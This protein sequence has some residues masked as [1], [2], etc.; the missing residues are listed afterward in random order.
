MRRYIKGRVQ[1]G[2]A[3]R[4][5]GLPLKVGN[6]GGGPFLNGDF[7]PGGQGQVHG[8]GGGGHIKGQLI[9]PSQHGQGVGA[10]FIGGI[11]IGGDAVGPGND[12]ADVAAL[13]QQAGGGIHNQR[14]RDA[15]LLKLPSGQPR[16]LQKGT[17]FGVEH[18]KP[19]A[20]FPRGPDDAQGRAIGRG[21][22]GPGVAMGQHGPALRQQGF[23]QVAHPPVD[24][25][26]LLLNQAGLGF[27]PGFDFGQVP[28]GGGL[29]GD[30]E[31][32]PH[33]PGQVDG[34]R[35]GGV[36]DGGGLTQAGQKG[37]VAFRRQFP[38]GHYH[39]IGGGNAD[40]RRAAHLHIPDGGHRLPVVGQ[41]QG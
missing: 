11:P 30:P 3:D 18:L 41:L 40:G 29:F 9:F 6:F 20:G 28:V 27:Q 4:S 8:A 1:G 16:S 2:Y 33:R 7:R 5:R 32:P 23:A 22:Q 35:A 12:A 19:P 17:G 13:H 37:G 14:R 36:D 24:V 10:D 26:V 34:G 15:Q 21:R 39:G 25:L 31:H 38:G